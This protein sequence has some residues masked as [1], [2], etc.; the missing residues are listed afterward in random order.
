MIDL[1]DCG[2]GP[3]GLPSGRRRATRD[4]TYTIR[5]PIRAPQTCDPVKTTT[6]CGVEGLDPPHDVWKWYRIPD[7][8]DSRVSRPSLGR[9]STL[10]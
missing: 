1:M 7:A 8:R 10:G 6:S 3:L 4:A 5:A 2:A 9:L